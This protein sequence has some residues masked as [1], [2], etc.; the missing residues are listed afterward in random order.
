MDGK[1]YYPTV[2]SVNEQFRGIASWYGKDFHGKKTS[3]GEYYDM[4]AMTAAHKTLPMNTMVKVTNLL[5]GR[6]EIVRINDRGPFVESRIIDLSYTAAKRLDV[7]QRGTAPARLEIMGFD[8]KITTLKGVSKKSVTLGNFA[9]QI[10]AFRKSSGA[11]IYKKRYAIVKNRYSSTV[12]RSSLKGEPI[13]RVW[14]EG[15]K[16]EEEAR[17]FIAAG[18]FKG[19]FIARD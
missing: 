5:N 3:N 11:D 17:D 15:F 18:E 16:S 6:S 9:V 12:K 14:I 4:Y 8:H 13:Y 2:V 7:V 19:A 10:G 1:K